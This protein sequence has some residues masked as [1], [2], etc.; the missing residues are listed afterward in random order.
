M[1]RR[2]A[3]L[4]GAA[5]VLATSSYLLV[6]GGSPPL[7]DGVGFPDEPYR[8]LHPPG[9]S[10][11]TKPPA[12]AST[13]VALL[14]DGSNTAV[15]LQTAEKGPQIALAFRLGLL[16]APSGARTITVKVD[17][18]DP[19]SAPDN[20]E[21]L[22][23]TYRASFTGSNGKP[24]T[25]TG[26]GTY[27]AAVRIPQG[28]RSAVAIE[29]YTGGAWTTLRTTQ[30]G[31]DVYTAPVPA[32]GDLAAVL[33]ASGADSSLAAKAGKSG[34]QSV[35]VVLGIAVLVSA[36]VVIFTIRV[37]RTARAAASAQPPGDEISGDVSSGGGAG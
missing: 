20:G 24:A 18:V 33:I 36:G 17:P 6:P 26:V 13:V 34:S 25:I 8:Y 2:W 23:N 3:L 9:G 21:I 35:L 37:S 15:T 30:T 5:A 27:S 28:T 14:G 31:S 1:S 7:Y 10:I 19:V 32:A 4:L 11:A 16:Q 12:G 29:L 22:G